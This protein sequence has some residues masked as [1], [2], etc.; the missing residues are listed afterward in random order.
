MVCVA[1]AL[2]YKKL[3]FLSVQYWLG[4]SKMYVELQ[5]V[6][7]TKGYSTLSNTTAR[8]FHI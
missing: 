8:T 7:I 6:A 5:V 2:L 1:L 4:T 3:V